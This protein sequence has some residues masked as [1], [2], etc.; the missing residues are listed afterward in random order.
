MS[1]TTDKIFSEICLDE[2]I[3]D[4]I[5]RMDE[6]AHMDALR[7]YFYKRGVPKE[8][9][10]EISNRMMEN[11]NYPDRQA[12]RAEDGLTVTWPTNGHK[13]KAMAKNPGKYVEYDEAVRRGIIQKKAPKQEPEQNQD[14]PDEQPA[15]QPD[16]TE[17]EP[18]AIQQNGQLLFVEPPNDSEVNSEPQA[19]PSSTTIDPNSTPERKEATKT[20]V[21]QMI[22]TDDSALTSKFYPP[23]SEVCTRQIELLC[24]HANAHGL[25]EAFDFLKQYIKK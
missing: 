24:Y 5:F 1:D 19:A 9:V 2:R 11:L 13:R 4:G 8:T 10:A 20:I 14:V 16:K 15:E 6:E 23:I 3:S 18:T 7:D 21:Q 22:A 25:T 12:V 17:E